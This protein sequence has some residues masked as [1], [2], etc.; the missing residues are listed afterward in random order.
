MMDEKDKDLREFL[1]SHDSKIPPPPDEEWDRLQSRI[2]SLLPI[3]KRWNLVFPIGGLLAASLL[4]LMIRP[5]EEPK[6][7][8][9]A[10]FMWDSYSYV[11]ELEYEADDDLYW[12][13][14]R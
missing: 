13:L 12:D 7:L 9:I 8:Q 10:E 4:F 14:K 1:K 5:S 11:D 3:W 6:N 2:H